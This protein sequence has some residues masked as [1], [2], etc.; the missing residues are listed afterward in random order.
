MLTRAQDI[1]RIQRSGIVPYR[2]VDKDEM[3]G[4]SVDNIQALWGSRYMEDRNAG[5]T[6]LPEY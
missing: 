5:S 4:Y 3:I 1:N 2:E 6:I